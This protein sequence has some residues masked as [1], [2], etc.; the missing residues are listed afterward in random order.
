MADSRERVLHQLLR[1]GEEL[2]ALG[3]AFA[4]LAAER[5]PARAEWLAALRSEAARWHARGAADPAAARVAD[6]FSAL[7]DVFEPPGDDG[8]REP[9][10]PRR[11]TR[12]KFDPPPGRWDTRARWRS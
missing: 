12:R 5:A 8:A 3:A 6:L 7:A 9:R 10:G 1:V 2:V 11:E 4:A